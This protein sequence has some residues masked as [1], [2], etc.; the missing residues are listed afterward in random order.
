MWPSQKFQHHNGMFG[1]WMQHFNTTAVCVQAL[2]PVFLQLTVTK[3][4]NWKIKIAVSV[5]KTEKV[6]PLANRKTAVTEKFFDVHIWP[7]F[8]GN[9]L[10]SSRS[11][12]T[13]FKIVYLLTSVTTF[14]QPY[15]NLMLFT[16]Q[17]LQRKTF[18]LQLHRRPTWKEYFLCVVT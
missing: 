8:A 17:R 4:N 18:C 10:L 1:Q 5:I 7:Y 14:R 6:Q 15:W 9:G 3:T 13:E 11:G 16:F 2:W 12:S